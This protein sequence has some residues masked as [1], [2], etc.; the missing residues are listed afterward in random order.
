MRKYDQRIEEFA[1]AKELSSVCLTF[2]GEKFGC[3]NYLGLGG[4]NCVF[5]GMSKLWNYSGITEAS[6]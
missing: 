5:G 6:C 3:E 1:R 2:N 4:I